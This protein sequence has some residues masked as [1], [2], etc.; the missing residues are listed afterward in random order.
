MDLGVT[1][2]VEWTSGERYTLRNFAFLLTKGATEAQ[3]P[4]IDFFPLE[5]TEG[6]AK[7]V[8]LH[9]LNTVLT[10]GASSTLVFSP[11]PDVEL[12]VPWWHAQGWFNDCTESPFMLPST[13]PIAEAEAFLQKNYQNNK[14]SPL[15]SNPFYVKSNMREIVT[16]Q[17]HSTLPFRFLYV[18]D[19]GVVH[20]GPA[21]G[22]SEE[23]RACVFATVVILREEDAA[24]RDDL[25]TGNTQV[26]HLSEDD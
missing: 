12:K 22:G 20:V 2:G 6:Q 21:T 23:L 5:E 1:D 11:R 13:G 8:M 4:H 10:E 14:V 3:D 16:T 7:R 19:S 25:Y 24:K 26:N 15:F 18:T 17:D 9:Q